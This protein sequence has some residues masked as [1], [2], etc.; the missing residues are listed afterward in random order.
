M[1]DHL[2]IQAILDIIL[3]V[4]G[5]VPDI[6]SQKELKGFSS[7]SNTR[8]GTLSWMKKQELDWPNIKAGAVIC[9]KEAK[10][11]EGHPCILIP[12]ENPRLIFT[13]ILQK[14]AE[15]EI[16]GKVEETAVIG[17]NCQ[18]DPSAYI[19]HY[20]VIGDNVVVGKNSVI[21]HH[22][23]INN[24][25]VIGENAIIK[26]HCV[27]GEKGFGFE[28]ENGIPLT[29]PHIGGVVIGN[30]VEI[31]SFTTIVK[32]TLDNTILRD[33]V[34]VDDHV[35]VAHNV[36]LDTGV[37][38]TACAEIS[39]STKIGERTWI[40]P[41]AS[42]IDGISVGEDVVIGMG[43]VITRSV[44]DKAIVVGN[45]GKVIKYKKSKL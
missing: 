13:K 29:V 12:V 44:E 5:E 45:P 11:P 15:Q 25:T 1:L 23:V 26:S 36:E 40:A 14:F 43:A 21:R 20:V 19:G 3:A 8:S 16:T 17:E 24:D 4:E 37:L 30:N 27:I 18:I 42:V 38:V 10:K 28:I 34:K 22:V 32:G 9:L 31:G 39:G 41:N 33:F 35:H 6:E 2:N 7:I